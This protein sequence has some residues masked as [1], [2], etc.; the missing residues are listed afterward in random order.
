MELKLS[1]LAPKNS[2]ELSDIDGVE[3]FALEAGIKY[4]NRPDV[5]FAKFA[6]ETTCAGV[7]TT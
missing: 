6:P 3:I 5:L 4:K 1:P 7:F 2:P